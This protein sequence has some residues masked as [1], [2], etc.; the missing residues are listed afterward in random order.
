MQCLQWNVD[1][2]RTSTL[3]QVQCL[4]VKLPNM[5]RMRIFTC[6]VRIEITRYMRCSIFTLQILLAE[7]NLKNKP[8]LFKK[9]TIY[10]NIS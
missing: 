9:F 6:I 7:V 10:V 4:L 3:H 2:N 1:V 8:T 5:H